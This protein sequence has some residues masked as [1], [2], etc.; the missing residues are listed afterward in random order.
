M[1][2]P[3][4]EYAQRLLERHDRVKVAQRL[5]RRIGN[6]RLLIALLFAGLLWMVVGHNGRAWWLLL[7]VAAFIALVVV[8]QRVLSRIA[9]AQR[10]VSF[11]QRAAARVEGRLLPPL[12]SGERFLHPDHPYSADLDIFGRGSLFELLTTARTRAGE[13][14]LARWLQAPSTAAEGTDRQKAVEELRNKLD[15]REDLAVL[16]EDFRTGVHPDA[17]RAWSVAPPV[18]FP[19]YARVLARVLSAVALAL[20]IGLVLTLFGNIPLRLGFVAVGL[21]EGS[22]FFQF[23]TRVR[24]VIHAVEEPGHDLVLLSQVLH[25]L[26]Q[27]QF[28]SPLLQQLRSALDSSGELP[29]KRIARLARLVEMRDSRDNTFVRIF[30]PALLWTTQLAFA[31]EN[32][33][34]T[35][36]DAVPR[37]LD[38]VGQFEALS[39]LASYAFEHPDYP[40]PELLEGPPTFHGKQLGHPLLQAPVPN[41]VSLD[42][43][44]RLLLVSGSNMSGKSTLLRTVGVN[45]VLAQAGS[46]VRAVSLRLT[47]FSVGASLRATDSL[48]GG[49]SR[50][51]AEI[52]RLRSILSLPEPLLFLLDELLAGTNSHDRRIGAEGIIRGLLE[53]KSV[54]LVTTHDLALAGIADALAPLAAN[55]HF[56]DALRNGEITF[57]YRMRPGVVAKSNAL[58]LM[59]AIGLPVVG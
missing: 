49:T 29:S 55:V 32:W 51:Y 18:V 12:E 47:P 53:R 50:F 28:T 22:F 43:E 13:E 48:Q 54:G 45:A 56:E 36:G 33:R 35:S 46:V 21:I 8:H 14:T 19:A 6:L 26:E 16:G 9:F 59:R 20:I 44:H 1:T 58:E 40:F 17:L 57:D 15:L 41:D 5:H 25:R 4:A 3:R 23:V 11:Y 24:R 37:W 30:G 52:K 38:A 34:A 27:E 7:P 10:S 42:T 2:S 31:V 39:S